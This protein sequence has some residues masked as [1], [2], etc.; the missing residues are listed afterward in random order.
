MSVI[1]LHNYGFFSNCSVMLHQI[2][3]C[4]NKNKSSILTV[5]SSK[6]FS[7]YK[8]KDDEDI[9]LNYFEDYK[10]KKYI[11]FD[12]EK[13]IDFE[14]EYQYIDYS[15]L[16]YT[17]INPFIL[18]YFSPSDN[19]K[20]I[21]NHLE[22]KYNLYYDNI[23]VLFYRGNDKARE[24]NLCGYDE[25]IKYAEEIILKNPLIKF[26]IQSDETGFIERMIKIFPNSFYFKDEIRHINKCN[27]TVDIVFKKDNAMFSKYYLAITIIMSKCKYIICG[28]GNCSLWI[29]LYR[30]NCYN[31]YQHL[32]DKF[33][34]HPSRPVVNILY[35]DR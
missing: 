5:D 24:T 21:V 25:Y 34:I 19:I 1:V 7:W 16:D 22:K 9:T 30:N 23:C 18:K 13:S 15:K 20:K 10:N 12:Q 14:H 32:N 3:E 33:I 2:V 29:M 27:N 35:N 28:S 8:E 26:L 17:N 4:K 11:I 6:T 31:V